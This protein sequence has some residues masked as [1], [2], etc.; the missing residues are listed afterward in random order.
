MVQYATVEQKFAPLASDFARE[1]IER[2]FGAELAA[3]IYAALPAKM[4]GKNKGQVKGYIRWLKC[5]KGGWFR[6]GPNHWGVPGTNG[7]V[8]TPGSHQVEIIV[9]AGAS[10]GLREGYWRENDTLEQKIEWAQ[11]AIADMTAAASSRRRYGF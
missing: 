4:S 1:F 11:R 9:A 10:G 2:R 8:M 5:T 6:T 7:H 3:A